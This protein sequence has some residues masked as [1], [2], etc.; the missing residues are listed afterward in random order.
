MAVVVELEAMLVVEVIIIVEVAVII[1]LIKELEAL[2]INHLHLIKADIINLHQWIIMRS[3][4]SII[5][6]L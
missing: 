5:H 2:S 1:I 6:L 4:N 3:N